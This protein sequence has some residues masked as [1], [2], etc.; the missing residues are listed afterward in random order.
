MQ[1]CRATLQ[2]RSGDAVEAVNARHCMGKAIATYSGLQRSPPEQV[3]AGTGRSAELK[4]NP[5]RST[6]GAE[7][8]MSEADSRHR[9]FIKQSLKPFHCPVSAAA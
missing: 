9:R 8:N 3:I 7:S 4:Q 6:N 5:A 2:P 1:I